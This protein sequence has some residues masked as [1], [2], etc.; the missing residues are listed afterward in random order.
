MSK[1]LISYRFKG[2]DTRSGRD[3]IHTCRVEGL[4]SFLHR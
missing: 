2:K 1:I 4:L 3:G